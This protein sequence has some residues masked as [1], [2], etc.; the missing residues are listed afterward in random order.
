MTNKDI[1]AVI[2]FL[3]KHVLCDYSVQTSEQND[4]EMITR[5]QI[6]DW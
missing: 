2:R 5:Q 4:E 1:A 3:G 6:V